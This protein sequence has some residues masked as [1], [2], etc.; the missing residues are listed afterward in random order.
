MS[1]EICL[2]AHAGCRACDPP[3]CGL[4]LLFTIA[5]SNGKLPCIG[6]DDGVTA[7]GAVIDALLKIDAGTAMRAVAPHPSSRHADESHTTRE[8]PHCNG[9]RDALVSAA[10][11]CAARYCVR[12]WVS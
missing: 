9:D 2:C 7:E 3:A 11:L 8:A 10:L 12:L 4:C 5:D 6:V 1:Q